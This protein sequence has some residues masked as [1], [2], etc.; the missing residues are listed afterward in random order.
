MPVAVQ[1]KLLRFM[2]GA[3]L[4]GRVWRAERGESCADR[5][6]PNQKVEDCLLPEFVQR[7]SHRIE[8]PAC[9]SEG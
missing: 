1:A 2:D 8:M 9:V 5:G 6:D 7:F 4:P 3:I